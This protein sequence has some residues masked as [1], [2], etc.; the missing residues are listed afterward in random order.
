MLFGVVI[1]ILYLFSLS[2]N[3][4]NLRNP[5]SQNTLLNIIHGKIEL[6]CIDT[7]TQT[8]RATPGADGFPLCK[9][10]LITSSL[11]LP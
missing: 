2:H 7:L 5:K 3:Y 8:I 1:L 4:V 9:E 10:D 6:T 11:L